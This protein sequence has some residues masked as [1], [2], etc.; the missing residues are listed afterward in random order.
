MNEIKSSSSVNKADVP[1]NVY[2]YQLIEDLYKIQSV[3]KW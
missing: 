2:L 3:N 1:P